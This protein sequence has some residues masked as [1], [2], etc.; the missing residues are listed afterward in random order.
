MSIPPLV[1]STPP[2]PEQCED[3]KDPDDFVLNYNREYSI[4]VLLMK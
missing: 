2:P 3:D 4:I 1:C